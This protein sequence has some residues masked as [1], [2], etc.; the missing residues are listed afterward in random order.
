MLFT[1]LGVFTTAG[2]ESFSQLQF[3]VDHRLHFIAPHNEQ[4]LTGARVKVSWTMT[5]FTIA[6]PGDG[7]PSSSAGYFA[8]FLDQAAIKPGQSLRAKD[9]E[10][11]CGTGPNCPSEA[12][13]N[14]ENVY[15][16]TNTS[17]TIP[18]VP[19][20]STVGKYQEHQLVVVLINTIGRRIGEASWEVDFKLPKPSL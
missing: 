18:T 16:T 12:A 4:K 17:V 1:F 2:C 13:L 11:D 8:V 9:P 6:G 14:Q 5:G 3:H 20:T 10:A 19:P 15:T 7:P